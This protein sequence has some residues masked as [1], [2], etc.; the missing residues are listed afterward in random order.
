MIQRKDLTEA[1]TFT[2]THGLKG[3]LHALLDIDADFLKEHPCFIVEMDGIYVPF[4]AESVRPKGHQA[5]L[6][7]PDDIDSEEQARGF[8]GKTLYVDRTAYVAWERELREEDE[9]P[10]GGYLED[11]IGYTI[12]TPEGEEIGLIEGVETSTANALFLVKTAEGDFVYIP[13]A[14]EFIVSIDTDRQRMQ[15]N[16]P[17]GLIDLNK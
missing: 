9:V 10:E 17:S 3:E 15:M 7:K 14:E 8:A 5:T 6:I 11:F 13:V 2:K 4:F 12:L 16:L 1:G